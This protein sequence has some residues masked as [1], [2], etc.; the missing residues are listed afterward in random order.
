MK[1][2]ILAIAAI[3]ALG[4][5]ATKPALY[6]KPSY[7]NQEFAA[8]KLACLQASHTGDIAVPVS[9]TVVVAPIN[10][11]GLFQ[12]CMESRGWHRDQ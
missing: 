10:N 5:C 12:T 3:C 6:S 4:G 1:R 7:T 9:G 2:T 8:D 11:D